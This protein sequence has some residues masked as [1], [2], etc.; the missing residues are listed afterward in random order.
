MPVKNQEIVILQ[1][2]CGLTLHGYVKVTVLA[3]GV[4][5]LGYNI[6]EGKS[7]HVFS[8]P[9]AG[10]KQIETRTSVHKIS[11]DGLAAKMCA[12]LNP[13]CKTIVSRFMEHVGTNTVVVLLEKCLLPPQ[14]Q[15]LELY[16]PLAVE[17]DLPRFCVHN[18]SMCSTHLDVIQVSS[19]AQTTA[20]QLRTLIDLK[21]K[22]FYLLDIN[23][24]VNVF[25]GL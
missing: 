25:C 8:T 2:E 11:N 16:L 22:F 19:D 6:K 18:K 1:H 12:I 7:V 5:I 4:S 15:F 20:E 14:L 3:G 21:G 9:R 13:K 23:I 24:V 10:K 17:M